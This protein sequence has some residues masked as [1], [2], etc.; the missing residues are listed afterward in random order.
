VAAI[1]TVLSHRIQH[2]IEHA[3]SDPGLIAAMTGLVRGI[4][5]RQILPRGAGLE[6]P[7]DPVQDIP[8]VAPRTPAPI[9][10]ATRLGQ[11]RFEHGPLFVGEVHEPTP[12]PRAPGV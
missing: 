5:S 1:A 3:G 2:P 8:R 10:P 7:Q 4:A 12:T 9:W 11:Q 6:D